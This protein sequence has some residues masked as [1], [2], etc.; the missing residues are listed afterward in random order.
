MFIEAPDSVLTLLPDLSIAADRRLRE[1][2]RRLARRVVINCGRGLPSRA[3]VGRPRP[4]RAGRP[5]ADLDLDASLEAIVEAR[6][7]D[8]SPSLDELWARDWGR[9]ALAVCLVVD[10]SGSMA[11]ERL[12]A[13]ALA[14][15]ACAWRAPSDNAV[16]VFS[17]EVIAVRPIDRRRSTAAVVDDLLR[18]QGKGTTDLAA[19]LDAAAAQL[20]R[21]RARRRVCV[22]LSD[23]DV[24]TGADPVAAAAKLQELIVIG[25]GTGRTD[26]DAFCRRTGARGAVADGPT[27]TVRILAELL[28]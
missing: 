17:D 4:V 28:A 14:A 3:G 12:V 10:R 9:A 8:R 6:A 21:S 15:A 5:G 2:A 13:A 1:R 22:L 19:A 26:T 18:L 20:E 25:P 16:L 24:N 11:G 7:L 23:C 27:A